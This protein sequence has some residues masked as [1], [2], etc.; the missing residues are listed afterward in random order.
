MK[1]G[2]ALGGGG[3]KGFAHLGVLEVLT[4]AGIEFDVVAGTSIGALIGAVYVSGNLDK[5][6]RYAINIGITDIP[7]LL[8]PTWPKGGLFSGSYV[9]KLIDEFVQLENIEDLKKP[10]AAVCV[11]LNNA[12]VVTFT[13]GNLKR[14][15][16]ASTSIPGI[17]KPVI[18]EDKL[19]VDGGVLES[20]PVQ[21]VHNLGADFVVAVDLLSDLSM[22]HGSKQRK[23]PSILEV[24]QRSSIITQRKITEYKFKEN[25][26][27]I[28]IRPPLSEVKVM[29]FHNGK[30]IMEIGRVAA[31]KVIPELLER[32]NKN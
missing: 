27:D 14:A 22:S 19:L 5:L 6:K 12:E 24:V 13:K 1:L 31:Q 7:F 21:A 9:D 10:F 11:D 16:R 25:P 28:V 18:F 30:S 8:G 4:E 29:D 2:L 23:T 15:I 26:P 17:F 32:I 20:V 3:A